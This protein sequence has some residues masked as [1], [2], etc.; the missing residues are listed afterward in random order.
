MD[1][2]LVANRFLAHP[3]YDVIRH[4]KWMCCFLWQH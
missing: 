2:S 3:V 1:K 4:S